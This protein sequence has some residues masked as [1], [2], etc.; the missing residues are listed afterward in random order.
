MF[1]ST[2]EEVKFVPA[3]SYPY[4]CTIHTLRMHDEEGHPYNV[5]LDLIRSGPNPTWNIHSDSLCLRAA[6][7]DARSH[8]LL[9]SRF[10]VAP[11]DA[12]ERQ[13][14]EMHLMDAAG[15]IA[16]ASPGLEFELTVKLFRALLPN[17]VQ[18]ALRS[19]QERMIGLREPPPTTEAGDE[20]GGRRPVPVELQAMD[21]PRTA[22]T[23]FVVAK[24]DGRDRPLRLRVD[25]GL[26]TVSHHFGD[27]LAEF[28]FVTTVPTPERASLIFVLARTGVTLWLGSA[29]ARPRLPV[30][31]IIHTSAAGRSTLLPV[32]P[33]TEAEDAQHVVMGHKLLGANV[34]VTKVTEAGSVR[35]N[36]GALL[37]RTWFG[38]ATLRRHA[39]LHALG[40]G[41]GET[42]PDALIDLAGVFLDEA[43]QPRAGS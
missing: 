26:G 14:G 10:V 13:V 18:Q 4:E 32:V 9:L 16:F 40:L 15:R 34:E 7:V 25:G 1:D 41:H 36:D 33:Q 43:E 23:G 42:F 5:L 6:I 3:P 35:L 30:G 2:P 28:A 19:L 27:A 11:R 20:M 17:A 12:F 31:Y 39:V 8:R 38:E 21:Y 24:V 22:H 29:E 37:T